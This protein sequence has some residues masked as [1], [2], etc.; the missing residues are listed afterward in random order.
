MK[1]S[2]T[3]KSHLEQI[4][5][6][7]V[8]VHNHFD[9]Y[10]TAEDLA[11]VSG[12]SIFHFHRIFKDI[13]GQNVNNYI[14]NTRLEKAS[15]LLLYNQHKTIE[16]ISMDSGFSTATGFTSAFKKKF[17]MTPKQWRKG[18]YEESSNDSI[19]MIEVDNNIEIKDPEIVKEDEIPMMYM[20]VYGYEDDMSDIWNHMIEWSESIGILNEPHRY[21]GLFHN[22]PSFSPYNEARYL[23]CIQ[24]TSNAF[25]SGKV[26]KCVISNGRF[27]KFK[28]TCKH[29]D[30]YKMMHL[31]YIKWLPDSSYEVRNFPGYVEYKNPKNLLNNGILECEFYMPVQLIF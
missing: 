28:F 12:Y 24:T 27:A 13:V 16:Q 11:E 1:K 20:R 5:L 19:S 22:H 26:G 17:G 30:L 4:N 15:N 23:A 21:I 18:G 10:I 2:T 25:R 29:K 14:R 6:S 7:L 31:A 3:N 9:S 8:Y